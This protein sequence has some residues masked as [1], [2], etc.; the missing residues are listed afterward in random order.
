MTDEKEKKSAE[1]VKTIITAAFDLNYQDAEKVEM[2]IKSIRKTLY[3][4][5]PKAQRPSGFFG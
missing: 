5:L 1:A 2:H 3:N 4:Q